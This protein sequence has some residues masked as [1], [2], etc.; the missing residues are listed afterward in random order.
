MAG[1]HK[2]GRQYLYTPEKLDERLTEYLDQCRE[3]GRR[4]TRPG[5]RLALNM[6]EDTLSRYEKGEGVY[7]AYAG[8]IKK[9]MDRIRDELEQGRDTMNIFLLKQPCYGGYTDKPGAGGDGQI[10]VNISFG[11]DGGSKYGK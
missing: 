3:D 7:K 5:M 8:P 1:E 11:G 6:S 2:G 9:A 4:P 10:N